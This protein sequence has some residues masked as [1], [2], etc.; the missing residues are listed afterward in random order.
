MY[1][2]CIFIVTDY[3]GWNTKKGI[4]QKGTTVIMSNILIIFSDFLKRYVSKY[5]PNNILL[6]LTIRAPLCS[7]ST[8]VH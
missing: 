5:L 2:V 6:K 8:K 3:C 7:F 1:N 4:L